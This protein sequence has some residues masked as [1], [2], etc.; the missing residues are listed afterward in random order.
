VHGTKTFV[1]L[2]RERGHRRPL[3]ALTLHDMLPFDRPR[4]FNPSKRLLVRAPMVTSLRRADVVLPVSS[5]TADRA[6]RHDPR[7]AGKTTTVPLAVSS[8]L[9]SSVPVPVARVAGRRFAL[10]VG[11]ASPR[12]NIA[13]LMDVWARVATKDPEALLVHVGPAGWGTDD[14]G[15]HYA[16][17]VAAGKVVSLGH[18]TDGELRWL[19]GSTRVCLCPS[20]LEGFGLPTAEAAYFGAPIIRSTDPAQREAAGGTGVEIDTADVDGWTAAVLHRL[21]PDGSDRDVR[22]EEP[23]RDWRTVA[24]ETVDAVR[25]RLVQKG[26]TAC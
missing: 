5:A 7:L 22:P 19:Y 11:D 10:T 26:A 20:H 24:Q 16:D 6:R 17:L 25:E 1:P 23:T 3:A 8:T 15:P 18:V 2:V 9:A 13:A 4:D 21:G 14:F 12:K